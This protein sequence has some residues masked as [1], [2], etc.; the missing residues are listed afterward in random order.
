MARFSVF[1]AIGGLLAVSLSIWAVENG[2]SVR[3]PKY[4]ALVGWGTVGWA[5]GG[6]RVVARW[7]SVAA[8]FLYSVLQ[9]WALSPPTLAWEAAGAVVGAWG[10]ALFL[11]ERQIWKN[12]WFERVLR[13]LAWFLVSFSI[14][15]MMGIDPI[16]DHVDPRVAKLPT[17]FLGHQTIH[18]AFMALLAVY[19]LPR[20]QWA[21]GIGCVFVVLAT[22]SSFS[23]LALLAGLGAWGILRGPRHWLRW[24]FLVGG[25]AAVAMTVLIRHP[26]FKFFNDSGR[27]VVWQQVVKGAWD[28]P[29]FGH[30]FHSFSQVYPLKYQ[31]LIDRNWIQ[32]H[33]E[34]LQAFFELGFVGLALIGW[35]L[36]DFILG[37][38]R[39]RQGDG[40]KVAWA[41]VAVAGLVNSMGNFPLHIAPLGLLTL[42]GILLVSSSSE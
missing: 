19:F 39:V 8:L 1:W 16:F 4:W 5:I 38:I 35:V 41:C 12:F 34:L 11:I 14:L 17:G 31:I 42:T 13:V 10:G 23:L 29:V 27:F 40:E 28:S 2:D 6:W 22:K 24:I 30:G 7:R 15:Q 25:L 9:G 26:T 21:L 33:N 36:S 37:L 32:A 3:D 18:G 20:S